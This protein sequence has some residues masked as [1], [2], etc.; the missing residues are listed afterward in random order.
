MTNEIEP[1]VVEVLISPKASKNKIVGVHDG[2]LKIRIAAPPVD[3]KANLEL[4]RFLACLL[5]I[6]TYD[7]EI[8]AGHTSKKKTLRITGVT[9]T[10]I[11]GT[12]II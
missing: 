11:D 8:V 1:I 12:L 5:D 6:P 10:M 4:I 2:R 3:G 7:I 9:K